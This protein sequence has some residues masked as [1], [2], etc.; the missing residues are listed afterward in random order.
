MLS[1]LSRVQV[2]WSKVSRPSFPV[3]SHEFLVNLHT[4]EC[5]GEYAAYGVTPFPFTTTVTISWWVLI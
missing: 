5:G 4:V 3:W 2:K 1:D